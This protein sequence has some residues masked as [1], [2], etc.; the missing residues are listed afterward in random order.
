MGALA[1]LVLMVYVKETVEIEA[2]GALSSL[3]GPLE[4]S[5]A[6]GGEMPRY[7]LSPYPHSCNHIFKKKKDEHFKGQ[8]MKFF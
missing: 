4:A 7:Q 8:D 1:P 6:D 3:F 5:S 2:L